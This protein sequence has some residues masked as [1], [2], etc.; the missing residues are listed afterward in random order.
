MRWTIA[1]SDSVAPAQES[2]LTQTL[3]ITNPDGV[4][5]GQQVVTL[6]QVISVTDPITPWVAIGYVQV[7]SGGQTVVWNT[8]AITPGTGY[9]ETHALKI[10]AY[11]AAG[12]K[13]ESA[14]ST[15]SVVHDPKALEDKAKE[16]REGWLLPRRRMQL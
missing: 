2:T 3:V 1:M 8:T 7:I 5:F 4:T 11:D 16:K 14:T 10:I 9:T 15:F 12:N 6:T 13:T